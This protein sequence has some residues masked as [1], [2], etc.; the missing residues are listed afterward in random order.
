MHAHT[1]VRMHAPTYVRTHARTYAHLLV[2]NSLLYSTQV[3]PL[4]TD[5]VIFTI[6]SLPETAVS[7]HT[8]TLPRHYKIYTQDGILTSKHHIKIY[9][10]Y[11]IWQYTS[12]V[13][14]YNTASKKSRYSK[15]CNKTVSDCPSAL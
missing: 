1:H 10:T 13:N 5:P 14:D 9:N 8:P 15:S 11:S 6:S 2:F 7:G 12:S 3:S 4:V